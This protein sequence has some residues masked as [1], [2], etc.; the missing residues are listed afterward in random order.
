MVRELGPLVFVPPEGIRSMADATP[1][2]KADGPE[3]TIRVGTPDDAGYA[4]W[5]DHL[6]NKGMIRGDMMIYF[7]DSDEFRLKTADGRPPGFSTSAS[8]GQP[9]SS[10]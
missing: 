8:S 4:Y 7:S 3:I 1:N 6:Q 2:M 5:L 9:W 10:R